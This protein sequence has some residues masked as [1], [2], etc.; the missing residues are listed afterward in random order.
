LEDKINVQIIQPVVAKYRLPLFEA[1]INDKRFNVTVMAGLTEPGGVKSAN[2]KNEKII[3]NYPIKTVFKKLMWQSGVY[4]LKEMKQGDV[5]IILGNI[6]FLSNYPLIWKAKR[7]KV[8]VVWWGHG[9]SSTTTKISFFIRKQIIKL[10]ADTLL[11]YTYKE[12]ELFIRNGFDKRKIFYMNNTIDTKEINNIKESLNYKIIDNIKKTYNLA[13]KKILL[14]VGRLR[15]TPSTDLEIALKSMLYLNNCVFVI[16]GDGEEKEKLEKFA[17]EIKVK[18]K[19]LFLGAIYDENNLA[20][21]FMMSDCFVY[22][23]SIGLSLLHA[24]SYRLPVVTHNQIHKHGPEIAAL[25]NNINGIL[26]NRYD[27]I[28]LAKK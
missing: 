4:L 10:C 5:L 20:P 16:I 9:W 3:L 13:N 18:D 27:Y 6:K 12:K 15:T 1:L 17:E 28:D 2:I 14:F 23:G 19:I 21:W 22:P 8:S 24:F 26:F 7:K 25:E 11:L